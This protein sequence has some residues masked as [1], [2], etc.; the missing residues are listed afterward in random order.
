MTVM[1]R[2]PLILL[3][4]ISLPSLAQERYALLIGIGQYPDEYGW[5]MI[6]GDNDVAIIRSLLLEQGFR[7][8]N[9]AILTNG[10]ATKAGIMTALGELRNQTGQGDVVYIHFSGHGQQVTDLDG[11]E[12]DHYDEAWVPFDAR[13]KYEAGVYEGENHLLDDELNIFLNGLRSKVGTQG[14]IVLVADACHSG[15][16]SRGLS[17]EEEEFV[18]GTNEKFVI[19]GVSSNV[20]KKEAT[21]YWLCVGACKPFQTNYEHKAADGVYY[22][23]LSYVIANGTIDL[24]ASDYRDVINLWKAALVEITRYPQDLDDEGRPSRRSNMLF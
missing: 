4:L 9:I 11:D 19:P 17:L 21:V 5:P 12:P 18:R 8:E 23:S 15:S 1:R 13:K 2:I 20:I 3:F 16:G 22:G 7:E 10:G 6:H 24:V 14:K